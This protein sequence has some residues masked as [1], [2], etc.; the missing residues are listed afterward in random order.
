MMP[1]DKVLRLRAALIYGCLVAFA[2]AIA[3]KLFSIQL[4]EGE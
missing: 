4:G 3:V 2:L 1:P